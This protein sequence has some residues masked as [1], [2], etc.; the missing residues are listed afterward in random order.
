VVVRTAIGA[1]LGGIAVFALAL[2]GCSDKYQRTSVTDPC[3]LLDRSLVAQLVGG[4]G[5]GR[6]AGPA[7]GHWTCGWRSREGV[8]LDLAIQVFVSRHYND[9]VRAARQSYAGLTWQS[10]HTPIKNIDGT[11]CWQE[12]AAGMHLLLNR[13]DVVARIAYSGRRPAARKHVKSTEI[14]RLLAENLVRHL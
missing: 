11:A 10:A 5:R 9:D 4:D 6:G 12:D 13:Y 14:A 3:R 7:P 2:I 1:L 8:T